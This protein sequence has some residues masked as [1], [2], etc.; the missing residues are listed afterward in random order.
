MMMFCLRLKM[1]ADR[2]SVF[3]RWLLRAGS[4]IGIVPTSMESDSDDQDCEDSAGQIYGFVCQ[5]EAALRPEQLGALFAECERIEAIVL[6]ILYLETGPEDDCSDE[7]GQDPGW[8]QL[9]RAVERLPDSEPPTSRRSAIGP[10]ALALI[11]RGADD[12]PEE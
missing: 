1:Q 2:V 7:C 6:G 4:Q 3:H 8:C 11:V 12:D 10:P 5:A 9:L